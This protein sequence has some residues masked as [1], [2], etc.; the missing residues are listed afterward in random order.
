MN[1]FIRDQILMESDDW[2]NFLSENPTFDQSEMKLSLA[3]GARNGRYTRL[4]RTFLRDDITPAE[5]LDHFPHRK[6]FLCLVGCKHYQREEKFDQERRTL[7]KVKLEEEE[8]GQL[9][10]SPSTI[11]KKRSRSFMK[12]CY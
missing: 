6:N 3:T 8:Q 1:L 7:A 10:S 2:L 11:Q 9:L 12:V 4:Q 5:L